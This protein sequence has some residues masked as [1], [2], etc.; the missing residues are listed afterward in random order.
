M[1]LRKIIYTKRSW[2]K[3][4]LVEFKANL[5]LQLNN[6]VSGKSE[7]EKQNPCIQEMMSLFACLKKNDYDQ[8]PCNKEI[9]VLNSCHKSYNATSKYEKEQLRMGILTPG[10]KN[11]NHRQLN[12][13]LKKYPTL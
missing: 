10:A 3:E 11:L 6:S 9:D 8:T 7:K 12:M 5:P 4:D 1:R 2:L 13:L